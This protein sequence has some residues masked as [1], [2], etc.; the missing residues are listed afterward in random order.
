MAEVKTPLFPPPPPFIIRKGPMQ[1]WK[2][3]L[4]PPESDETP[5]E[6]YFRHF[7]SCFR[8]FYDLRLR[9]VSPSATEA[10]HFLSCPELIGCL[11]GG[12][13]SAFLTPSRPSFSAH[14]SPGP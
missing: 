14:S 8:F 9:L 3:S 4:T 7:F 1:Q 2:L 11:C 5:K 13:T 12:K 6:V 10:M